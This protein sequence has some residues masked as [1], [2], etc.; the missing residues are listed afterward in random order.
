MASPAKLTKKTLS[1][2]ARELGV[3]NIAKTRKDDLIRNIQVAE[4]H[5]DC[6]K[7]IPDCGI[8]DC[9]FRGECI[10]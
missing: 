2:M 6:Y 5:S 10:G 9:L 8:P 7:H 1:E 3:R 4:G